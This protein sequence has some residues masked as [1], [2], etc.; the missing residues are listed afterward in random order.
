MAQQDRQHS[1]TSPHRRCSE[2]CNKQAP[3]LRIERDTASPVLVVI[4]SS[5]AEQ[6][7]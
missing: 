6:T 7:R 1:S 5:F 3:G 4:A 2:R